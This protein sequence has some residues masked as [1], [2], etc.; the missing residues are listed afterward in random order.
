MKPALHSGTRLYL[1]YVWARFPSK[2]HLRL[3]KAEVGVR[4]KRSQRRRSEMLTG[5]VVAR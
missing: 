5:F 1:L 3:E 2:P 4:H